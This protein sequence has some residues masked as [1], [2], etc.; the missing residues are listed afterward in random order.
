MG[1]RSFLCL[2]G[3]IAIGPTPP[4][5]SRAHGFN[6]GQFAKAKTRAKTRE[7]E[8]ERESQDQRERERERGKFVDNQIVD[9]VNDNQIDEVIDNQIDERAKT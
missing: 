1:S 2:I 3:S 7:R 5:A 6:S 9:R 8:R 4:A